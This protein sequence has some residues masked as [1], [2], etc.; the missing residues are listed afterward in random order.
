M[1]DSISYREYRELCDQEGKRESSQRLEEK[2]QIAL[3]KW[4]GTVRLRNGRR[5]SSYVAAVPNGGWRSPFEAARMKAS[6]LMPGYPDVE[7]FIAAGEFTGLHIEMKFGKGRVTDTQRGVHELL[8]EQ[9]RKVV[10]C[11]S[12]VAAANELRRYIGLDAAQWP[13]M[14]YE[15]LAL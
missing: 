12:W 10:A 11:W 5:L 13:M 7:C 3:I 15:E 8:R 4:C 2:E 14:V 9:R 1:S 6:G